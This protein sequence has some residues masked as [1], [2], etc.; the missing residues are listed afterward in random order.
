LSRI[1]MVVILA[2]CNHPTRKNCIETKNKNWT[3]R[4]WITVQSLNFFWSFNVKWRK[5]FQKKK[6]LTT[7]VMTSENSYSKPS[8]RKSV[9][10]HLEEDQFYLR[11]KIKSRL[12][13]NQLKI[14]PN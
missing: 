10:Y 6:N 14:T 12:I 5:I 3:K 13:V 8:E 9:I 11:M 4:Y 2:Q 1:E 7:D